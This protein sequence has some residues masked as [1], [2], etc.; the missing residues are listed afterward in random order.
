MD[1]QECYNTIHL[2]L[3]DQASCT[4]RSRIIPTDSDP[5]LKENNYKRMPI[6]YIKNNQEKKEATEAEDPST[7]KGFPLME[8]IKLVTQPNCQM[9]KPMIVSR[10]QRG[11]K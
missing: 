8:F 1:A 4:R 7:A 11:E 10:S 9:S 5:F 6:L 2:A 3:M